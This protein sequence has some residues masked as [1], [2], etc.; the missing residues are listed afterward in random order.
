MDDRMTPAAWIRFRDALEAR[1]AQL[2]LDLE[3]EDYSDIPSVCLSKERQVDM[4]QVLLDQL[5]W[6]IRTRCYD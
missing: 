2:L 1:K 3:R 4:I 6:R 5:P